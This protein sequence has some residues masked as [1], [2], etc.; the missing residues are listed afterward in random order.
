MQVQED[1]RLLADLIMQLREMVMDPEAS[2]EA[3]LSFIA[4]HK[5]DHIEFEKMAAVMYHVFSRR[6]EAM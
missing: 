2:Q 6:A 3:I 1:E 5:D 4:K